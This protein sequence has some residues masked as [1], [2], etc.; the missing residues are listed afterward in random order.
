MEGMI[1]IDTMYLSVRY[2][3][4]DVFQ[5]WYRYAEGIDHRKLKEGVVVG[6]FVVRTGASGYKVSVW[7]QD[8]RAFLTSEVDEK[9]GEGKGM[10]IWVQLGPK[11]LLQNG[12]N[13]HSAVLE[14]LSELGVEGKHE[15]RIT[16]IDIAIDLFD[17]KINGMDIYTWQN[18]WV[19]RPKVKAAFFNSKMGDLETIQIGSRKSSV[20]LR[21]YDKVAQAIMDGDIAYW[22]EVWGKPIEAVTR[23]EWQVRPID[24]NFEKELKDF[25]SFNGFAVYELLNYLL[26][27]GRLCVPDETDSNRNRWKENNFWKDLREVAKK[28][29][30]GYNLPA[31]RSGKEIRPVT[32]GYIRYL[33]G[34][35]AGGM[36]RFGKD[37]P[38]LG[39]MFDGLKDYGEDH[40]TIQSKA[41]E[42]YQ[43]YKNLQ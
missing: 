34:T 35:I 31:S 11:F 23:V 21:I 9:R 19:G 14:L 25:W 42:K 30:G 36:A 2:P 8:A 20:F 18:G 26:E 10:G 3:K 5:K 40:Q 16:R 37:G 29:T 24:G 15:T 39:D 43:R 27:W 28:W 1:S 33:S 32:E 17:F 12:E 38:S 7:K 13:I 41:Q 22:L 4:D 6:N